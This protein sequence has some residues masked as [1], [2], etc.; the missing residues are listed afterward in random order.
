VLPNQ[1]LHCLLFV[2]ANQILHCLLIVPANQILHCLLSVLA[3]QIPICL[4]FCLLTRFYT[5]CYLCL[6]TRFYCLL[7][8]SIF[9]CNSD[10]A[11]ITKRSI[12]H[13]PWSVHQKE[14]FL[15]PIGYGSIHYQRRTSHGEY[16]KRRIIY[17]HGSYTIKWR[18]FQNP[19]VRRT[20]KGAFSISHNR[21]ASRQ[22]TVYLITTKLYIQTVPKSPSF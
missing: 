11:Y 19:M 10:G 14:H 21:I 17:S 4:L 6:L 15:F 12:F 7:K 1:I 9:Y 18:I 5:V 22:A 13:V 2:T 8:R 3:N 20:S 16:I